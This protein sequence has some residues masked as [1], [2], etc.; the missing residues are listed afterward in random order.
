M[1]VY[2]WVIDKEGKK[3]EHGRL[4]FSATETSFILEKPLNT[5]KR[6]NKKSSW[7]IIVL[8]ILILEIINHFT[9]Y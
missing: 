9:P 7:F 3:Y 4:I 5:Q 1:H 6:A 8:V 2:P